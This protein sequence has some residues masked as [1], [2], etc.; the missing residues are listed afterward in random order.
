MT[1]FYVWIRRVTKIIQTK[2]QT[3]S[4]PLESSLV[5]LFSFACPFSLL[6][7]LLWPL[8]PQLSF[9][10]SWISYKWNHQ[11]EFFCDRHLFA[12]HTVSEVQQLYVSIALSGR[13]GCFQFLASMNK[14]YFQILITFDSIG[15]SCRK[16][17]K[18]AVALQLKDGCLPCPS[19]WSPSLPGRPGGPSEAKTPSA[20]PKSPP[21]W[22]PCIEVLPRNRELKKTKRGY[23]C[24]VT[25]SME[26]LHLPTLCRGFV[27]ISEA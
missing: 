26:L 20:G 22:W 10:S 19:P 18:I 15:L 14:T 2:T 8:S 27:N 1:E 25:H 21:Y 9:P 23:I 24:N 17:L 5:P 16:M 3:I 6:Q 12:Q 11:H 7:S 4:I 13:V